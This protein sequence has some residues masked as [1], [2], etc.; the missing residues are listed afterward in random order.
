M[1]CSMAPPRAMT[2]ASIQRASMAG[3]ELD[4][5]ALVHGGIGIRD[6]VQGQ[7]EVE[8]LSR[9]S[10]VLSDTVDQLGQVSASRRRAAVDQ[11]MRE[12]QSLPVE[13][14]VL[15]AFEGVGLAFLDEERGP[16]LRGSLE[17]ADGA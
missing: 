7:R 5:A 8:D 15:A 14:L 9:P 2:D 11:D 6:L 3:A 16:W 4:R 10:P 13:L 12:D 1:P 17:G